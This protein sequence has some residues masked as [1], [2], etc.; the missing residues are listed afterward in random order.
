VVKN[1]APS[2]IF[3]FITGDFEDSWNAL[4]ST[5]VA[6]SRGN[7]SFGFQSMVLL[8]F[9]SRLCSSADDYESLFGALETIEPRYFVELPEA[10]KKTKPP[11]TSSVI[12]PG[13][14]LSRQ[15]IW[16]LYDIVRNGEAHQYQRFIVNLRARK[17]FAVQLCGPHFGRDVQSNDPNHLTHIL[18]G[19]RDVLLHICPDVF[20]SHVK[21]AIEQSGLLRGRALSGNWVRE[22]NVTPVDLVKSLP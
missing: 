8:E 10:V 22:M 9:G 13:L 14:E 2:E 12:P 15:L 1:L 21:A 18:N 17:K 4:A 16:W 3:K 6:R 11:L 5:A 7:F 19:N 20:F